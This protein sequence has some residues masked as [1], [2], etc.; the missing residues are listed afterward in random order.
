MT[1]GAGLADEAAVEQAIVLLRAAELGLPAVGDDGRELAALLRSVMG[2]GPPGPAPVA[3]T[4][5]P[6]APG[7]LAA[8]L[9]GWA[10][11]MEVPVTAFRR[12]R[13]AVLRGDAA[14]VR[15]CP[16]RL[17]R[18]AVPRL[19]ALGALPPEHRLSVV[20]TRDTPSVT[21]PV[22]IPG[23]SAVALPDRPAPLCAQYVH[24]ELGHVMEL[25]GRPP[26]LPLARRWRRPPEVAEWGALVVE[27][28]GRCPAWLAALDVPPDTARRI[29]DHCRWED[30]YTRALTALILRCAARTGRLETEVAEASCGLLDPEHVRQETLRAG[31]WSA[32][33]EGRRLADR[34][35]AE[36]TV[37]WGERWWDRRE[38]WQELH[39]R[40]AADG[41]PG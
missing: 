28:L 39:E 19:R 37:V 29:A 27:A 10:A 26:G 22:R 4:P 21:F 31:Y 30:R 6:A 32:I 8:V 1:G 13:R 36:F 41:H 23:W 2:G 7:A 24:H 12:D 5:A 11:A 33:A 17:L 38:S 20:W 18:A 3:S 15:L 16:R 34:T 35:A 25:A 14:G 40:L 9:R